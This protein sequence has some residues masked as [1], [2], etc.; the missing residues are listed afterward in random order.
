MRFMVTPIAKTIIES[1]YG[2]RLDS[3]RPV[4]DG[5]RLGLGGGGY[6]VFYQTPWVHWT[7]TVMS[8]YEARGVLF[9][10][11]VFGSYSIPSSVTDEGVEDFASYTRFM[12]KY[13][14]TIVGGYRGWVLKTLEKL[15]AAGVQP[16]VVA[17]LHGLVLRRHVGDVLGLYRSWASGNLDW[18]RAVVVY[19]SMYGAVEHAAHAVAGI[20]RERG[21][22]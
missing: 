13:L 14:A 21:S 7:D 18:G 9:S 19:A 1:H 16:R 3:F 20:L 17:P 4:R 5:V 12:R 15:E 10:G 8:F 11:D 22:V 2:V 6:L